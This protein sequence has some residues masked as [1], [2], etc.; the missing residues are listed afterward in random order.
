MQITSGLSFVGGISII[1]AN[2]AGPLPSSQVQYIVPGT[3]S[4]TAPTDVTTVSVLA[5]GAGGGGGDEFYGGGGGGGSL[6][7]KNNIAVVPGNSYTV[8][9][10]EG[11]TCA[12]NSPGANG[13]VRI[14]WGTGRA[15]PSTNTANV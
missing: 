7:Y 2:I 15:Y 13:A 9:V 12:V 3:Y 11:G 6:S 8:V 14:M 4:W 1:A 5:V 10:G